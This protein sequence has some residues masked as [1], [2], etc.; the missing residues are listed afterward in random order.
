MLAALGLVVYYSND[1]LPVRQAL[2]RLL[3]AVFTV[4][5]EPAV[6]AGTW[7]DPRLVVAGRAFAVTRNCTYVDLLLVLSPFAWRCGLSPASN[8]LR[9]GLLPF[10]VAGVD[11]VRIVLA[12]V[13]ATSYGVDWRWAHFWPDYLLHWAWMSAAALFALHADVRVDRPA[14]GGSPSTARSEAAPA[15]AGR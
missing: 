1:W 15:A 10:V 12:I 8:L 9:L 2:Q 11:V 13:L 7:G 3:V 14:L 4:M 5:G 6:A